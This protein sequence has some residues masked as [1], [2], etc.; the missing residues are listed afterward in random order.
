[1]KMKSISFLVVR[2]FCFLFFVTSAILSSIQ[3]FPISICPLQRLFLGESIP[4]NIFYERTEL[5]T[6]KRALISLLRFQKSIF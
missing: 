1:M 3:L 5:C 6:S 4:S 2:A